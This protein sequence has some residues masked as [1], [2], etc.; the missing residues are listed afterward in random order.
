MSLLLFPLYREFIL[1]ICLFQLGIMHRDIKP[2][3]ILLDTEGHVVLA[4]YGLCKKF[5]VNNK[6]SVCL[7]STLSSNEFT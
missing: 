3:N 7:L 6:V 2:Q 1:F 4:D 5:S